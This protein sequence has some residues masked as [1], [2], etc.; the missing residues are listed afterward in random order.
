MK[1]ILKSTSFELQMFKPCL[2][3]ATTDVPAVTF[4]RADMHNELLGHGRLPSSPN[5]AKISFHILLFVYAPPI[6]RKKEYI[7]DIA[8]ETAD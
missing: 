3:I 2:S 5:V 8:S 1:G 4:L 7:S 6:C